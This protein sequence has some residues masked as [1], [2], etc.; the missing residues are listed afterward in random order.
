MNDSDRVDA[1]YS[2]GGNVSL[3]TLSLSFSSF[4]SSASGFSSP[5]MLFSN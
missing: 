1:A 5:S 4:Y 2:T 3:L